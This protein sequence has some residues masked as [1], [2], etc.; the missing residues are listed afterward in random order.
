MAIAG[1]GWTNPN[2]Y[3][4]SHVMKNRAAVTLPSCFLS[5]KIPSYSATS[6]EEFESV[7]CSTFS[8]R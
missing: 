8:L 3:E 6:R 2:T 1:D 5:T 7:S 4:K